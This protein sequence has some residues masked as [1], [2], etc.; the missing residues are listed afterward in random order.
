MHIIPYV[1]SVLACMSKQLSM[2]M[3]VCRHADTLHTCVHGYYGC[4]LLKQSALSGMYFTPQIPKDFNYQW[5]F[6]N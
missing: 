6:A 2:H 5:A 3:N 4:T 1:L